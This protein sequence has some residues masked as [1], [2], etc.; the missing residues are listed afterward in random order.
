MCSLAF[1]VARKPDG[2]G[3]KKITSADNPRFKALYKLQQ[4]SRERRQQGLSLLDGIHLVAAYRDHV[5]LPE[6]V[7]VSQA[8]LGDPEIRALLDTLAPSD[9]L[10]LN[11]ALFKQLSSVATPT[12][13]IAVIKTPRP[14][15]DAANIDAC[16]MLEDI[17][18]P[19]NLGSILRTSAAAGIRQVFLSK[20]SVHAWSP[21]VLRAG[22]GAHFMLQ[23]HEQ[24]DLLQLVRAFEGKVIATSQHA[25]KSVFDADLTGKVALLFGNEGAGLSDTLAHAAR[26]VVAIPMSGKTESLNAAAAAAVCLF[27]RVRQLHSGR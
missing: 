7:L 2:A 15:A 17:Q 12:G 22:M 14:H 4:S 26:E 10:L 3:V 11:D 16:V 23:I 5:G 1:A 27:E 21:R 8:G 24:C 13:V 18:D 6:Q 25:V 20:G 9:P 19:G